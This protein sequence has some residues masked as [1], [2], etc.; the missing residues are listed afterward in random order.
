[1]K[2]NVKEIRE[3]IM[4]ACKNYDNVNWYGIA[5]SMNNETEKITYAQIAGDDE[6]TQGEYNGTEVRI[7]NIYNKNRINY[8]EEA[9]KAYEHYSFI[10]D[11]DITPI[12]KGDMPF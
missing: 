10:I 2:Y 4:E 5:L 7:C 11:K 12:E 6:F 1:M 8:L 9:R 3:I